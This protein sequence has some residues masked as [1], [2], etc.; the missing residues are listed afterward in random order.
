MEKA[1]VVVS[2]VEELF[3]ILGRRRVFKRGY[4]VF[5][6][7]LVFFV[8]YRWEIG[9]ENKGFC[10]VRG[11]LKLGFCDFGIFDYLVTFVVSSFV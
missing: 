5:Y 2:V 1:R 10:F 6:L 3:L 8:F 9:L 4:V 7:V 11:R